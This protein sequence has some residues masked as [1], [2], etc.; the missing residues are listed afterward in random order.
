MIYP[1]EAV[2][3]LQ[4]WDTT[5]FDLLSQ[6]A[7]IEQFSVVSQDYSAVITFALDAVSQAQA[8]T[9]AISEARTQA[10]TDAQ[11]V[12]DARTSAEASELSA[13]QSAALAASRAAALKPA[14]RAFL[15]ANGDDQWPVL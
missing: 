15:F 5:G 6:T 14:A 3:R 1:T 4:A 8:D 12:E 7:I 9:S 2:S 13:A 11:A 10:E